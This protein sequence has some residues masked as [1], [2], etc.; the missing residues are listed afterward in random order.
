[1]K[2]KTGEI[3]TFAESVHHQIVSSLANLKTAAVKRKELLRHYY[4]A[5]RV[6]VDNK[7]N[8]IGG[9][10]SQTVEPGDA[11]VDM[12]NIIARRQLRKKPSTRY[13]PFPASSRLLHETE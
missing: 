3:L 8:S 11:V 7:E 13:R 12:D 1:M 9:S 4:D 2:R 10:F 5:R 6:A